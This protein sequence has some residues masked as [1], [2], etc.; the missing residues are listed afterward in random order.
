M[1]SSFQ[2]AIAVVV[3]INVL[4]YTVYFIVSLRRKNSIVKISKK[5]INKKKNPDLIMILE[6]LEK[7]EKKLNKLNKKSSK[8]NNSDIQR[9]IEKCDYCHQKIM[10][11]ISSA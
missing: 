8:R 7:I 2:E 1:V 9:E 10:N 6:K 5:S 4:I 3:I 11:N